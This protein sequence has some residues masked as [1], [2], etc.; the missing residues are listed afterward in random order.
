MYRTHLFLGKAINHPIFAIQ[1]QHPLRMLFTKR[2]SLLILALTTATIAA[3]AQTAANGGQGRVITTA[4][5]FLTITPDARSGGMGDAGIAISPDANS[6]YWNV[7]KLVFNEKPM[8]LAV[9]YTPWLTSLGINDIYLAH[10]AGYY[11]LTDNDAIGLGMT[12]FSLGSI[13]FTN[14]DGSPLQDVRP[15]E[16]CISG[17]YSRKL[18]RDFS[19]G[20]SAKFIQSRL[21]GSITAGNNPTANIGNPATTAAVDLGA[22]YTKEI[23]LRGNPSVMNFGLSINNFGPQVSYSDKNAR[24]YIPTML[25]LGGSLTSQVDQYNKV[26][27]AL[28]LNKICVPTPHYEVS[29][30]NGQDSVVRSNESFISGFASSLYKADGGFSEKLK[31]IQISTGIEYWYDDLFAVRGGYFYENKEKGN[32]NYFSAGLGV[33]Y[34]TLGFDLS[35]IIPVQSNNPLSE[36]LRFSLHF[37]INSTKPAAQP[38]PAEA[39]PVISQ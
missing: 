3:H 18:S 4:V 20:L 11:K 21:F 17:S 13:Q 12:Y 6:A 9:N 14:I 32:R 7:G 35:Y 1:L 30:K 37:Q 29:K 16:Y 19:V 31:E 39:A 25:R 33:R 34:Q 24:D 23:N 2:L 8:G 22:Y 26:T 36:T 38:A 15:N 27:F 28:D 10:L 5:P